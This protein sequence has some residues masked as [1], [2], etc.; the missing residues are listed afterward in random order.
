MYALVF[1]DISD[2][3]ARRQVSNLCLDKGLRRLQ[4]SVFLGHASARQREQLQELL[5]VVLGERPGVIHVMPLHI[6]NIE[7]MIEIYVPKPPEEVLPQDLG[8]TLEE[9]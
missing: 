3:T 4:H 6:P 8:A 7:Q 1:Y 9:P 2:N 5:R